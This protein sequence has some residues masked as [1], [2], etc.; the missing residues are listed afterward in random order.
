MSA[1][2]PAAGTRLRLG[3]DSGTVAFAGRLDLPGARPTPGG[4][5][6]YLGIAWDDCR[7]G[8]RP[9]GRHPADE[10]RVL[11]DATALLRR[12]DRWLA[13][14]CPCAGC[15]GGGLPAHPPGACFCLDRHLDAGIWPSLTS[16]GRDAAH[17]RPPVARSTRGHACAC[18]MLCPGR[19]AP[20][21][22]SF[23]RVNRALLRELGLAETMVA[24]LARRYPLYV[25]G[26]DP[27]AG[28]PA[29]QGISTAFDST[30]PGVS[31]GVELFIPRS[32]ATGAAILREVNLAG[33]TVAS[34]GPL[35]ADLS[36][37]ADVILADFSGSLLGSWTEILACLGPF[38]NCREV[39][40]HD[41][42]IG[43]SPPPPGAALPASVTRLALSGCRGGVSWR[44]VVQLLAAGRLVS[45][46]AARL[47]L[48]HLQGA[49]TPTTS[50][51]HL[52]SLDLA[53]NYLPWDALE[54]LATLPHLTELLLPGNLIDRIEPPAGDGSV[55]FVF[56]SLV[57]LDLSENQISSWHCIDALHFFCPGLGSLRITRNP[58][59]RTM[60]DTTPGDSHAEC[61][62]GACLAAPLS[63]ADLRWLV[64][65]RVPTLASL[66]GTELAGTSWRSP[67]VARER[68]AQWLAT[69]GQGM[70]PVMTEAPAWGP[71]TRALLA[72]LD[73]SSDPTPDDALGLDSDF[74]SSLGSVGMCHCL[75]FAFG[76]PL[77]GAAGLG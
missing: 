57:T 60:A 27:A 46:H 31:V 40:L 30:R 38:P 41:L 73:T 51:A 55:P 12:L 69:A 62:R 54:P 29:S 53:Y 76:L 48:F 11:F 45:L 61:T 52:T 47:G 70:C 6:H 16:V 34:L 43:E 10:E 72:S 26:A 17:A 2:L 20:L 3:R 63:V 56:R 4:D 13:E 65:A 1:T 9:D 59:T 8:R 21:P 28:G 35:D 49:L 58:L 5:S 75:C 32:M 14:A 50:L 64:P 33:S 23:T 74:L 18:L 24:A 19:P 37:F 39:L 22:V 25:C 67:A 71:H 15:R 68:L 42:F 77:P 44:T 36:R 7:R 66:N